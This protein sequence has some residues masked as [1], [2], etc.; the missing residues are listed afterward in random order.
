MLTRSRQPEANIC[1]SQQDGVR[2]AYGAAD[3]AIFA[4]AVLETVHLAVVARPSFRASGPAGS[5][6]ML[7]DVAVG[8]EHAY[9]R[10]RRVR[11]IFLAARLAKQA[12]R[13]ESGGR[14]IVLVA[15]DRGR[16]EGPAGH[17]A[18]RAGE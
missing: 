10:D 6:Q 2:R 9:L 17:C 5:A 1:S 8:V 14:V 18:A 4:A 3:N 15:Q 16:T 11:D 7:Y 13:S 12:F